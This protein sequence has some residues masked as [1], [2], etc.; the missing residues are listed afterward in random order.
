MASALIFEI[1]EMPVRMTDTKELVAF[2]PS[3][4]LMRHLRMLVE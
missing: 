1:S 2:S 4:L 3:S